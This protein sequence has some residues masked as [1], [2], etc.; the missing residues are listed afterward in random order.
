MSIVYII[1]AYA[2]VNSLLTLLVLVR[3]PAS[4][5]S[6]F[7][8]FCVGCLVILGTLG[9]PTFQPL[10]GPPRKWI[11]DSLLFCYAL[12]PSF[13]LHFIVIFSKQ[14][15]ILKS[16]GAM[17]AIYLA[18]FFSFAMLLL[19]LIPG[20]VRS[21]GSM[22]D[23]GFIFY[24]IWMS[25][26]L[27]IGVAMVYST[28]KL[29]SEREV[30]SNL[31]FTGIVL[32][33][34]V[35]PGPF[36]QTIN[37]VLFHGSGVW[38]FYSSSVALLLSVYL[39][40]RHRIIVNTPYDILKTVL[41]GMNDLLLKTDDELRIRMMGGPVKS[42]LGFSEQE[43]IGRH[44]QEFLSR[45]E[46]LLEY[47]EKAVRGKA[48]EAS[49]E[50]EMI[51][52][53]GEL[54]AMSFSF[55]VI[56]SN[57][58]LGGFLGV[59]RDI[60][61]QKRALEALQQSE[62][63]F[64]EIFEAQAGAQ[65]RA[66]DAREQVAG[67]TALM[68]DRL[69]ERIG[70]TVD[71]M[72]LTLQK[73]LSFSSLASHELRT[74]LSILRNQLEGAMNLGMPES[75]LR[76]VVVS[77]YDEILRLSRTVETLLSLGAMQSGT[78]RLELSGV[79]LQKLL[80]DFH[81]DAV[82]LSNS[83]N[84]SVEFCSSPPASLTCDADRIRQILFNLLENALKHTPENGKIQIGYS[85]EPPNVLLKFSDNGAGISPEDLPRIF[86]PFYRGSANS[87]GTG[88]GLAFVQWIMEAHRGRVTAESAPGRGTTFTLTL[89][90][91]PL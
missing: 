11:G 83:K 39:V 61:A 21:D 50:G 56:A 59:A 80:R 17:A 64:R 77:A 86:D 51:C 54:V 88:L 28:L 12:L 38:Y 8:A 79:D 49:F 55:G 19:G 9:M 10:E 91:N 73:T 3:L 33:L 47:R 65:S 87:R 1:A 62:S 43:M 84:I 76:G 63:R 20:P 4:P 85:I 75:S 15:Q 24:I 30:K 66:L 70:E 45:P 57:E 13:F 72:G 40:F 74:P 42:L 52:K 14:Q 29:F 46:P 53:N 81:E 31:F 35:L 58:A 82:I 37:S 41:M 18:G 26:F 23:S 34:L 5:L 44:L 68:M 25:V 89:P 7:F 2:V 90:L 22:S 16:R 67:D 71:K 78:F 27:S 60:S 48:E 6:R 32:V 69:A 36:T